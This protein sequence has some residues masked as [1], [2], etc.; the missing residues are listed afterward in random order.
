LLSEA[1]EQTDLETSDLR[2]LDLGAGSGIVAEE[3]QRHGV[4]HIV[5]LDIIDE[6]REAAERDRPGVYD[7][8]LV[9]DLCSP[10][11]ATDDALS[12]AELNC[13][14]SVAALGFG[15][16]PPAAFANAFNHI[17]RGGLAAFNLRDRFLLDA[18][19]SGFRKLVGRILD[20]SIA[21]PLA[22]RRYVHRLSTSGEPLH[23][24][25]IVMQKIDDVPA[26][27]L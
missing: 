8:Y 27:W 14:T 6:A 24:V 20:E 17:S 3:L 21:R 4:D 22:K 23:Y 16:I 26:D 18:D 1:L 19:K 5:G 9:A 12:A 7:S 2:V 10:D 15:D 11:A 13:L 25:A